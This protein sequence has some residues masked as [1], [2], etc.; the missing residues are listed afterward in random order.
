MITAEQIVESQVW[1][2]AVSAIRARIYSAFERVHPADE[3]G[4]EY[5]AYS[6]KSLNELT[7]EMEKQMASVSINKPA[8]NRVGATPARAGK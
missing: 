4:L 8:P 7:F 6:L 1:K 2:S 5:L 3:T